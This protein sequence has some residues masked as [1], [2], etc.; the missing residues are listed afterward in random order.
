MSEIIRKNIV[1]QPAYRKISDVPQKISKSSSIKILRINRCF[2]TLHNI[3][4]YMEYYMRV[5]VIKQHFLEIYFI[6]LYTL[7]KRYNHEKYLAWDKFKT[8]RQNLLTSVKAS[9][10]SKRVYIIYY[11]N[12]LFYVHTKCTMIFQCHLCAIV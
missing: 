8:F 1:P 9:H 5:S 6:V 10:G 12:I 7:Y 11:V 4:H 3:P 2:F